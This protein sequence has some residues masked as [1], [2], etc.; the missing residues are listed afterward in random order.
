MAAQMS[1]QWFE[2]HIDSYTRFD[3]R[4]RMFA[5][6][7]ANKF[8][9]GSDVTNIEMDYDGVLG[10]IT[11]STETYSHCSCCGSDYGEFVVPLRYLYEDD[12][13]EQEQ[14]KRDA[15]QA[16]RDKER[17][18]KEKEK[19]KQDAE[20]ERRLFERLKEKYK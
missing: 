3:L 18:Q 9:A 5:D 1:K 11:I 19:K 20:A 10:T 16:K 8:D 15:E 17:K 4:L 6:E 13:V 12:W 2:D 7:F 14:T